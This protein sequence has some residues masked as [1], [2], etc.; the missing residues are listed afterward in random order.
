[1]FR[2]AGFEKNSL[3]NDSDSSLISPVDDT[4]IQEL[5]RVLKHFTIGEKSMPAYDYVVRWKTQFLLFLLINFLSLFQL[6]DDKAP[7]FNEWDEPVDKLTSIN[8]TNDDGEVLEEP[9]SLAQSLEL[10]GVP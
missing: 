10:T 7:S 1:M 6:I 8:V 2:S 5:D 4:A 9:P 3:T